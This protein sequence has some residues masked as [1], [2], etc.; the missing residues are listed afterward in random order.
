MGV[1]RSLTEEL[2][3]VLLAGLDFAGFF[4]VVLLLQALLLE[5]H[6]VCRLRHLRGRQAQAR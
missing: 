6:G 2:R 3:A 1:V 4:F 5:E